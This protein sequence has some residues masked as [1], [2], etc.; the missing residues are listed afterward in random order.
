MA[1]YSCEKVTEIYMLYEKEIGKNCAVFLIVLSAFQLHLDKFINARCGPF[2]SI[3]LPLK[4]VYT[5]SVQKVS[6]FFV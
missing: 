4:A 6:D 1:R 5:R 2:V 3:T